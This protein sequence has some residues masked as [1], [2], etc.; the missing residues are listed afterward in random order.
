MFKTRLISG[1]V[2]VAITILV[3]WLGGPFTGLTIMALSLVGVYELCKV[4]EIEKRSPAVLAYVWTA[5]YY[6]M[7]IFRNVEVK[8]FQLGRLTLPLMITYLLAILAA[9][10]I[11]FPKYHDREIMAAFMSFFYVSVMLSYI[12]K[13]RVMDEGGY[14]VVLIFICSWGND[15]LAYCTGML[16]GKHK[17][18]PKL[19]PKKSV[20][21]LIGGIVGAGLLGLIYGIF[22][23]TR[24]E[25]IPH[26]EIALFIICA[27]GAIPAV[28]G[29]LA[30][31]AIKRN[32]DIKDYG[33]LIPG[34]GGV[35]DR[36]DSI[37][38]TAPIIYYLVVFVAGMR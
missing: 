36:F 10:V 19:S 24:I 1:I 28:I 38:F 14:F 4:Y 31:S 12:Y 29:D 2:L 18:S 33:K 26:V 6:A 23:K 7:L 16:F 15:T 17:M 25:S 13:I 35:L 30:A 34:H 22:L 27:L 21:G 8:G 9:Y 37:I 5:I 20:E 3:L 32:N 11:R